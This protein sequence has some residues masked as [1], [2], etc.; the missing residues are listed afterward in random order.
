MINLSQLRRLIYS[1]LEP[2]GLYSAQAEE[3]LVGTC[4][5]ESALG[6]YIRQING[7]ALGIFQME[8]V[9]HD[10]I[11]RNYL[12]YNSRICSKVLGF[13]SADANRMETDLRH[14]TV[15]A[16]LQYYRRP[17]QLPEV[18]DLDGQANYWKQWYNT[19]LG[20]GT[21]EEY[22]ENYVKYCGG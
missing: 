7:P 4:A 3:L 14:A 1:S 16:R 18:D 19:P 12:A 5:Q 17:E 22:K 13:I 6:T 21:V 20:K 2:V 9:T 10:D 8:P 15:M 11:M